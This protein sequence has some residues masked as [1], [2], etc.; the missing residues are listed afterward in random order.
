MDPIGLALENFDG[1]GLWRDNDEGSRIDVTGTMYDGSKLDGAISVRQAVLNRADAF[2]GSFTENLLAY[3][4]G[5]V[6]DYRDMPTVRSIAREAAESN[7]RFS[8]FILGIVKSLA[9]QVRKVHT[10]SVQ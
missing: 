10:T 2:L 4:V 8:S 1:I 9:F 7:N 6:L 3:G 5:R